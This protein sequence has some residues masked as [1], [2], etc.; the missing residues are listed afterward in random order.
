MVLLE[1]EF[2]QTLQSALESNG[3]T[4]SGVTR[5]LL[6]GYLSTIMREENPQ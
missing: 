1:P 4:F 6:E 3:Q 5:V 2:Y